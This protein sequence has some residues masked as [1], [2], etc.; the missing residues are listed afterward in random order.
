MSAKGGRWASAVA[1]GQLQQGELYLIPPILSE[2][3][4]DGNCNVPALCPWVEK[5]VQGADYGAIRATPPVTVSNQ[6]PRAERALGKVPPWETWVPLK[7][8]VWS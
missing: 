6:E 2:R 7:G 4:A 5:W 3:K 1:Q 8:D